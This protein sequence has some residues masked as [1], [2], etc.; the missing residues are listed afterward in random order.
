MSWALVRRLLFVVLLIG[1]APAAARAQ[2]GFTNQLE[3]QLGNQ[4][5]TEPKNRVDLYDQANLDFV[6]GAARVGVRFETNQNSENL[7]TYQTFTQRWAEWGDGRARVRVGNCYTILGAGLVHR[8]F[9]LR[10]VVLDDP[11]LRSRYAPT[12]DV[13]GVLVE[14]EAGPLELRAIGGRPN[15]GNVSPAGEAF[16][17]DRYQGQLAGGQ[18][19]LRL[20]R[21]TRVGA[22]YLRFTSDGTRQTEIGSGFVRLDPLR[23]AG[24]ESVA[25]PI[26]VEQ[27]RI[28]AT[29]DEWWRFETSGS[30]PHALY[31][32]SNFVW[33]D[34]ALSAEWKD[35]KGFR[36]GTNDPPSL[37][38]EQPWT[39]LNRA[40]HVLN[41]EDEAGFQLE[42]SWRLPKWATITLN[43]SR[44]DGVFGPR[45][46]R[47]LET[48]GELHVAPSDGGRWETTVFADD[49]KDEFQFITRRRTGGASVLARVTERWSLT[50][51]LQAQR[52]TRVPNTTFD[53]RYASFGVARAGW[54][55]V[56][57][58]WERSTD[59]EQEDPDQ[60]PIPG[61]APRNFYAG[62][63]TARLSEH[64][65]ATMFVGQRRGGLQ[66]TAGTCYQVAP[67]EGVELKLVSRF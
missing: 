24:I 58:V 20:P 13:D 1:L 61:I 15:G 8:S 53:D 36:L 67:F 6:S 30:E 4:P 50:G 5:F 17:I 65:E 19:S 41:A 62:I 42:G 21:D 23:L 16:D 56:S 66:C 9:E 49:G 37:V 47:F 46:V 31:A 60:V 28:D 25:L 55:T 43:R 52:S 14:G 39:L 59:P 34:V 27:A 64:H 33:Q 54:G 45:A 11:S 29:F 3:T 35:Y 10:G 12:R 22:T 51:E 63:V 26:Y 57:F 48:Y 7:Y 44:S 40:T 38:R 2:L 32:S 18:L